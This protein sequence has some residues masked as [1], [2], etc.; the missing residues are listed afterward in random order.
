MKKTGRRATVYS[1]GGTKAELGWSIGLMR[2][3]LPFSSDEE[4]REVVLAIFLIVVTALAVLAIVLLFPPSTPQRPTPRR[5]IPNDHNG[6]SLII[7]Q[8]RRD[9]AL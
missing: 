6:F 8:R 4:H 9:A 3:R 1:Q 7:P 5:S 2:Y